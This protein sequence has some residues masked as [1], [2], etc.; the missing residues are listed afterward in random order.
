MMSHIQN[1]SEILSE[2]A[3]LLHDKTYYPAVDHSAY[4]SCYQLSKHIWL[5]KMQKTQQQL[6]ALCSSENT[7]SHEILIN[8][9]R[10]Y[11]K[12]SGKIDCNKHMSDYYRQIGQLKKLRVKA[13]YSDDIFDFTSSSNAINLSAAI[14][15]ILKKY[16]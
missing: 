4:Y 9:I 11:I 13:D 10:N 6:D 2:A 3:K 5:H 7:G 15:P 1:K 8:E 16:Q 14:I 12:N